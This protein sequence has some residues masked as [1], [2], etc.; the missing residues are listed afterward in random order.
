VGIQV[1]IFDLGKVLVDFDLEPMVREMAV[2]CIK[3]AAEF[4]KALRSS[5]LA[6]RYE[7]G[8][9][10]T[11]EFY[12]H[13]REAGGLRM[14]IDRFRRVWSNV[15]TPE[16][17]VPEALLKA[18][19][20]KYRLILLSN[21]NEAHATFIAE[22]F[23]VLDHFDHKIFSFEV[24]LM[25]PDRRIYEHAIA[26]AGCSPEQIFFTDD[27][28]ENVEAARELGIRTYRFGSMEGLVAALEDA[29]V[30]VRDSMEQT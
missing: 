2:D 9:I 10:T 7:T 17:L 13:L 4:E 5:D 15:F 1:I 23:S 12:E 26:L 25:K 30:D 16:P 21:T 3:P 19:R 6:F 20:T 29:G 22:N 24:G 27:R 18:L 28:P 14:D 11:L 8:I